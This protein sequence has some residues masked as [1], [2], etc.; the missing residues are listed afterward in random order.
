LTSAFHGARE[1]RVKGA[2]SAILLVI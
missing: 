1:M 2:L